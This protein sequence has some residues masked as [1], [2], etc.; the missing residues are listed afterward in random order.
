MK[1]TKFTWRAASGAVIAV[2]LASGLAASPAHG[3]PVAMHPDP[4]DSVNSDSTNLHIDQLVD[5]L[6][7]VR[8]A[9]SFLDL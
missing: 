9:R 7:A 2:A 3:A 1:L 8:S 5:H 6:D 4:S